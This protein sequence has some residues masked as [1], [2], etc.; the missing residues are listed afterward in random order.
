LHLRIVKRNFWWCNFWRQRHLPRAVVINRLDGGSRGYDRH[1]LHNLSRYAR[2]SLKVFMRDVIPARN[3]FPGTVIAT[4]IFS[5]FI[6][7]NP[8]CHFLLTDGCFYG[9]DMFYEALPLEMKKLETIFWHK[10]FRMLITKEKNN[11]GDDHLFIATTMSS[12]PISSPYA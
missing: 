6:G 8:H 4:Q 9:E 2:E 11:T 10:A 1:L 5:D 12:R 3:P 7:F